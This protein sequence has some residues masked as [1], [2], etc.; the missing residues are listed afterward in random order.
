MSENTP[1]IRRV[2]AKVTY[3]GLAMNVMLP[4][5]VLVAAVL[6]FDR[7][8]SNA[9]GLNLAGKQNVQLSFYIFIAVTV[10]VFAAAYFIRERMP[11]FAIV[12]RPSEPIERFDRSAVRM[13]LI[14]FSCNS[15]FTLFG[16]ILMALGAAI[17]VMMLFAA[18]SMIGYQMLRP[19][20]GYLEK[21]FARTSPE[22]VAA[23]ENK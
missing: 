22:V 16:F 20:Q 23:N 18:L 4:A 1:I 9:G 21:L 11:N 19:R 17:E 10:L 12:R 7:D 8:L 6:L 14:I 2:L 3:I 13:G 15:S 5:T